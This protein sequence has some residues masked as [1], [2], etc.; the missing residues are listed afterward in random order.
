MV[1]DGSN[2]VAG[3]IVLLLPWTH[4]VPEVQVRFDDE[5]PE[6]IPRA[7]IIA[8]AAEIVDADNAL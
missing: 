8:P 1:P 6:L 4:G 7:S 5:L 3:N 2:T